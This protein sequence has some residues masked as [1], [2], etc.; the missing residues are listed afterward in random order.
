MNKRIS[1][2][3]ALSLV[4]IAVAVTFSA[5]TI[6]S[7]RLFDSKV[8]SA[9]ERA[10]LYDELSEIDR[11]VR[12]YYY[13]D[14]DDNALFYATAQGFI[15][16]LGDPASSYLTVEEIA[17]RE[18]EMAGATIGV[19]IG[20]ERSA[21]GYMVINRVTEG[22]S[23]DLV[24]LIVGDTITRIDDLD[25]LSVGYDTALT[26][27]SGAE[28]SRVVLTYNRDGVETNAE[29]TRSTTE[30]TSVNYA[31]ID[32]IAYI[33]V[34]TMN[35]TT[36]SQFA[37]AL[38]QARSAEGTAGLVIDLRDTSGGY[39]VSV[40]AAMLD[41]MLPAGDIIRGRYQ[42]GEIRTIYTSD[43]EQAGMNCAVLVNANTRGFAE[44]FAAVMSERA[45]CYVVGT[46]TAGQG[47]LQ[48]LVRLDDG[49]GVNITVAELL[50]PSDA[51]FNDTGLEPDLVVEAG[52]NF[53]LLSRPD[54]SSD[55]Q[56]RRAIEALR[57][58]S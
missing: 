19:G 54:E 22:S 24:G 57:S 40:A 47:T 37:S 27:L 43:E 49:S 52:E 34:E 44:L 7:M 4:L 39:D 11:I 53:I 51:S 50:T 30:A 20:V 26:L 16:G 28:G 8:S 15:S 17:A 18:T 33:R 41:D 14:I 9:S 23:A 13:G 36:A 45:S 3:V 32:D 29:L 42:G 5:A 6:Y 12:N 58:M 1:V 46:A 25:V 31:L 38:S 55:A 56:Y 21:S 48:Q 35:N 2:G 10:S